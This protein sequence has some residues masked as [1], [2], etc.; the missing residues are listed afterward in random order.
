MKRRLA[1]LL[2]AGLLAVA[3]RA[4][5]G[6]GPWNTGLSAEQI[7]TE[8]VFGTE[9]SPSDGIVDGRAW[10]GWS[11]GPSLRLD[12]AGRLVRFF[13][14]PALDH[15]YLSGGLRLQGASPGHR[16]VYLAGAGGSLRLNGELYS[17]YDYREGGLYASAKRYFTP[18]FSLELRADLAGRLYPD[19]PLEDA[20]K[21][22]LSARLSRS[23][24]SRT[25]LALTGRVGAKR[26]ASG[27]RDATGALPRA[28]LWEA[29][30]SGAQSLA[31]RLS[32]R[33][34]WSHSELFE[35]TD[36]AAQL[37]AFENPLLD[38]FSAAGERFGAAFKAILPW[39][40]TA[41]FAGERTVLT[42]PGRP[43][44]LYDPVTDIHAVAPD[45]SLA[46]GEGDRRDTANRL[47]L[48]LEKRIGL[49]GG[50]SGLA[51]RAGAE[52]TDQASND[53]Y[54]AWRGWAVHG[55]ASLE[56]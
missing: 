46:L 24:P 29:G 11:P 7:Y 5:A 9:A 18:A 47:R 56:F 26:Y 28:A 45:A 15:G 31:A 1:S 14:N 23:L 19:A 16:N 21:G 40:C 54:W 17:L 52:W 32:V 49:A 43:P 55:G 36:S 48:G 39:N 6:D 37:A 51:L 41:E 3:P 10:V 20:T 27:E 2:L 8:N 13:A 50:A 34:W 25:S 42:Y 30:L 4:S 33:A 53:L 22:W 44:L 38:E 12:A 35:S